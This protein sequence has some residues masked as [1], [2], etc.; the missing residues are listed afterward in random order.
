MIAYVERDWSA[1]AEE[2][3]RFWANRLATADP[4]EA[5]EI[6]EELRMEALAV[7]PD[8]PS[9]EERLEDLKAHEAL[10]ELMRRAAPSRAG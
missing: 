7:H 5:I 1:V 3:E 10:S 9:A 8:W 2:K 4:L 6:A